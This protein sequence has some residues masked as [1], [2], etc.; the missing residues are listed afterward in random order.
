MADVHGTSLWAVRFYTGLSLYGTKVCQYTEVK[1]GR[2]S[3][4]GFSDP[5]SAALLTNT[6]T[7]YSVSV[8]REV[9]ATPTQRSQEGED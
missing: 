8:L 1:Y 6:C 2:R 3:R 7:V 4:T 5:L 9:K